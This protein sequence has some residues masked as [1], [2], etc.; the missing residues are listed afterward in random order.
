[1]APQQSLLNKPTKSHF[2]TIFLVVSIAA[3]ISSS[4]L[5]A[6]YFINPTSFFNLSSPNHLCDHALDTASCLAHVSEVAQ[7]PFLSTPTKDH[8]YNLLHSFLMKSNSHIQNAMDTAKAIKQ[9][10][11]NPREEAALRDCEELMELSMD[12]VWDSMVALTKDTTDSQQDA[13]TWLSSV[14]TNHATCLDGLEGT[15]KALMEAE[16]KDLISRARTS[17]AMLVAVLPKDQ[18]LI[19][20][21]LN[22]D[23]PSWVTSKDRKLLQSW[24]GDIQANVVVAAD[25]SGKFKTVAEAVASVPDKHKTRY[26]I[27]VKKGTYKENVEIGS[28]K[29]NVMLVGDGMDSTIITGSLNHVDGTGTFQTATVAAVGDGFIAQDIRFQNTAGPQKHQAVALR[30][31]ADRSVINRCRIDAYQDTLYAHSNRQ[32]YR[33]SFITGTID[34][35][36]GNAAVVLQ[37][38]KLVAR[39]PMAN[40]KNMV[41]AQG[42]DDPNQNTGTSIQQCDVIPSTDLKPVMDS[43][44]TFLGRPWK[45]FSRTVVMQSLLSNHIDPAG[46]AEWDDKSKDFL[47]KL[48]YGEYMNKGPGA[49]TAKRVN[50]PGYHIITSEAEA[51]K[52]TVKQFIQGDVWLKNTGVN[53]IEGL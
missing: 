40:Q 50:W 33:D 17:L 29:W 23:F 53:Y 16:L 7:G 15:A 28:K 3:V 52:F 30:V 41:T 31:G 45:N 19:E 14:L 49:G 48:Y 36:F 2:K 20:E 5:I 38:C 25:G 51:S 44:P 27:Y 22:G 13:H 24:G 43:I 6:S 39:K 32:F 9:R 4:A 1:M 42:R 18:K 34:F 37:K 12:R 21:P 26:V 35:I 47:Y 10:I 8:K 46:W 11:N